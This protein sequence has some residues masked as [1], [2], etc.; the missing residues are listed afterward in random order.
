MAAAFIEYVKGQ[1][2]PAPGGI[3]D[4]HYNEGVAACVRI[5]EDQL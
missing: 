5:L 2:I 4:V 3:R 1:H